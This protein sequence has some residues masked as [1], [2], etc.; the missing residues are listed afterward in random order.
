MV[1]QNN[2]VHEEEWCGTCNASHFWFDCPHVL[3]AQRQDV[4]KG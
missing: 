2:Y 1:P 3:E 4:L